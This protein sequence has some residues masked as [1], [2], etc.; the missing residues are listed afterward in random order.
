M[1]A[2]FDSS[3]MSGHDENPSKENSVRGLLQ[4]LQILPA[5]DRTIASDRR[6]NWTCHGR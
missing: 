3:R 5:R 2:V 4:V 1:I 6:L